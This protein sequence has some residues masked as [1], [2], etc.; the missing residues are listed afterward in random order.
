MPSSYILFFSFG[1][2]LDGFHSALANR[3][4]VAFLKATIFTFGYI[5]VAR[6]FLALWIAP[7]NRDLLL[8]GV[9]DWVAAY[10][11]ANLLALFLNP[12]RHVR[13]CCDGSLNQ[14]PAIYFSIR[15]Y[16]KPQDDSDDDRKDD[17]PR[18]CGSQVFPKFTYHFSPL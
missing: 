9:N 2:S 3:V 8:F 4:L 15:H 10:C 17:S 1:G 6:L 11:F 13:F 16:G 18:P 14:R 12:H 5:N 7:V